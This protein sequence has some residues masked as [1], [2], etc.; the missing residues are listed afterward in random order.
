ML[1]YVLLLH[2]LEKR[3]ERSGDLPHF[4]LVVKVDILVAT[5]GPLAYQIWMWAHST[6]SLCLSQAKDSIVCHSGLMVGIALLL[7]FALACQVH[8]VYSWED[9]LHSFNSTL[10]SAFCLSQEQLSGAHTSSTTTPQR[11]FPRT[12]PTTSPRRSARMSG[13]PCVSVAGF[14]LHSPHIQT[15]ESTR[16]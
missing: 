15:K 14:L 6:G 12:S 2:G 10:S 1:V 16:W 9:V 3:N 7:G 11:P 13:T 4:Y 8:L 5:V